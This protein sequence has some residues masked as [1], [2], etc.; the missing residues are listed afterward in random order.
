M[1]SFWSTIA[2]IAVCFLVLLVC[3]EITCWYF[4]LSKIVDLLEQ[5]NKKFAEFLKRFEIK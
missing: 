3:R 4:K 2:I 5:Q 1:D